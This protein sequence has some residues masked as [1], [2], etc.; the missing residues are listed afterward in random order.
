MLMPETAGL[1]DPR[2]CVPF[3]RLHCEST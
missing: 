2:Q 1:R 3:T